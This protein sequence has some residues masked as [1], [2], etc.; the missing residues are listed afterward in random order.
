MRIISGKFKGRKI[1]K[2]I[3]NST[4]PLKDMVKES[5]FNIIEHSK[6]INLELKNTNI[7]DLY[8]GVGSFGLECLSRGAKK[9]FFFEKHIPALNI[10]KKNIKIL[11]SENNC[12]II[13]NDVGNLEKLDKFS[14]C[15]FD[16]VF[17]DPPFKDM[18]LNLIIEKISKI[19]IL[20]KNSYIII[21]RNKNIL[22]NYNNKL[23]I[24]RIENYGK[25]KIIFARIQN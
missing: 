17:L 18:N 5:M 7:L 16:L 21:H 20:K 22:E 8:S 1:L 3:D 25:S 9:V 13:D 10:L 6:L 23:K 19:K 12:E 24:L 14:N 4:R 15:Q 2:S 11:D